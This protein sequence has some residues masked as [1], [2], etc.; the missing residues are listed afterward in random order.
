LGKDETRMWLVVLVA[1][2]MV[3][4]TGAAFALGGER[5]PDLPANTWM[6]LS[7][8]ATGSLENLTIDGGFE[9]ELMITEGSS[10]W[11]GSL[12]KT[13]ELGDLDLLPVNLLLGVYYLDQSEIETPWGVKCVNVFISYVWFNPDRPMDMCITYRGAHTGLAYRVDQLGPGLH[14]QYDLADTNVTGF[15]YLDRRPQQVDGWMM[16]IREVS[17]S[18]QSNLNG[19]GS[20]GLNEPGEGRSLNVHFEGNNYTFVAFDDD[21]IWN[22][23][24][25]GDYQYREDWCLFGNGTLDY[26]VDD[27]LMFFMCQPNEADAIGMLVITTQED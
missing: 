7:Y 9:M 13:G 25:G 26:T 22:M 6:K 11:A 18:Y 27:G 15:E 5:E 14:V 2:V 12:N 21:D 3:L 23:V 17:E 10:H 20:C 24:N 19:G 8:T 16:E 4:A 1:A